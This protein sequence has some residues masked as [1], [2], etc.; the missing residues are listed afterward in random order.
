MS[1]ACF[2]FQIFASCGAII[3]AFCS[4]RTICG[5]VQFVPFFICRDVP[6]TGANA[7]M[8]RSVYLFCARTSNARRFQCHSHNPIVQPAVF[9]AVGRVITVAFAA[10]RIIIQ[11]FCHHFL[12]IYYN[13]LVCLPTIFK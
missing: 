11:I 4:L 6:T 2:C 3:R 10:W 13:Y 8:M 9:C 7:L 12:T 1:P 5:T